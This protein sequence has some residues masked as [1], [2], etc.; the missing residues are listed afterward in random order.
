MDISLTPYLLLNGQAKEA[1]DFYTE[2]FDAEVFGIEYLKDWPDEFDGELPDGF[3][4]NVMHAHLIIGNSALMLADTLP[5]Q[6]FESGSSIDLMIDVKE[7]KDAESLFSSLLSEGQE[8]MPLQETGFSPAFGQV[9]DKFGIR[10]QII[11][12]HPDMKG[13]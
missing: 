3:E 11:A 1:V 13:D 7:V 5:G 2:V 6:P 4:N 12:E 8:L 9:K 10:W